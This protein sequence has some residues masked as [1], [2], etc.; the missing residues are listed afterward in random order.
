ML[1][2]TFHHSVR[3]RIEDVLPHIT[4]PTL[5]VRGEHD[6]IVPQ[7]WADEATR[8]LPNGRLVVLEGA[9]HTITNT[10][11]QQLVEVALPFLLD[12]PSVP[13]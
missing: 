5:V 1:I 2:G 4:A 9:S 6:P 13:G 8:L 7:R 12:R 3:H 11:P 10:R